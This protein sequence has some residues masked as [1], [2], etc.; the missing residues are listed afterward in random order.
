MSRG[1][2]RLWLAATTDAIE[3]M[4]DGAEGSRAGPKSSI[5]CHAQFPGFAPTHRP[6]HINNVRSSDRT[7]NLYSVVQSQPPLCARIIPEYLNRA[8]FFGKLCSKGG[9]PIVPQVMGDTMA[10]CGW[11]GGQC[12]INDVKLH[13]VGE[14][15]EE[16]SGEW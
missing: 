11:M 7:S 9:V 8:W 14:S 13:C 16:R 3:G 2:L 4:R 5:P 12:Q 10:A 1:S 15:E 6:P